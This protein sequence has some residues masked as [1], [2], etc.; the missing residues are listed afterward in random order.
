MARDV[1]GI[2]GN[3]GIQIKEEKVV[4]QAR[5]EIEELESVRSGVFLQSIV[6]IGAKA[7]DHVSLAAGEAQD[8]GVFA[9]HEDKN[10]FVEI[11]KALMAAVGLPIIRIALQHQLLA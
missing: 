5:A 4:I 6:I 8:L 3:G 11:R 1:G 9:R 10:E 2:F 7:S